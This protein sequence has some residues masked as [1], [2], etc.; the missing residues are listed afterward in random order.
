MTQPAI[1]FYDGACGMCHGSV[2]F[3]VA[4]D[5]VGEFQ[6]AP[7]DGPTLE[8]S[9]PEAERLLLPDSVVLFDPESGSTWLRSEAI[10]RCLLRLGGVWSVVG[11]LMAFVPTVLR[12][13]VYD[14]VA[15]IRH[16]IW[17]PPKDACP[18]VPIEMRTR[19][20]P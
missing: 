9:M 15:R 4:R 19:F 7:L 14:Q 16:R 18:V 13:I 17:P 10:R 20:L 1:L 2:K 11:T 12:D 3:L 6:Y 8:A 5:A